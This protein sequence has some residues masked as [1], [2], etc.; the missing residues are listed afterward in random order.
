MLHWNSWW[1]PQPERNDERGYG[2]F[3]ALQTSFWERWLD[4]HRSWWTMYLANF[5]TMPWPPAGVVA[6]PEPTEP[7]IARPAEARATPLRAATRN[8][9]SAA[10]TT[11]AGAGRPQHARKR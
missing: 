1:S 9:P 2:D 3:I 7:R 5:P 4:M 8:K 10:P 6:P 11:P